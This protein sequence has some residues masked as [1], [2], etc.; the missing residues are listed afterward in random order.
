MTSWTALPWWHSRKWEPVQWT[1][2]A[3]SAAAGTAL[4]VLHPA[5]DSLT[6]TA[7]A[8][9]IATAVGYAMTYLFVGRWRGGWSRLWT[10][11]WPTAR[12]F[13]VAVPMTVLSLRIALEGP[14][15]LGLAIALVVAHVALGVVRGVLASRDRKRR[16]YLGVEQPDPHAAARR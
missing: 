8:A 15:G 9:G 16:T 5:S 6:T 12:R 10:P 4:A 1:A 14:V 3:V 7:A 2:L 13:L 11:S